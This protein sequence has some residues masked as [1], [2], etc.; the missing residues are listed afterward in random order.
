MNPH[1]LYNTLTSIKFMVQ[2]GDKEDASNTINALISLLQNT[3]G[4]ISETVSIEQEI[5]NLKNYVFINLKRYGNR[6]KVNY[7]VEPTCFS[8]QIPKLILQPFIENAF[9]HAFNHKLEGRINVLVWKEGEI[10]LCEITDDGDGMEVSEENSL[11][12]TKRNRKLFSGIGVKN[13]N[14]R[15]KLIYGDL[16]G[17][18]IKSELNIGTTVTIRIPITESKENTNN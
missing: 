17:V 9:F 7:L 16:Y 11:P 1:F 13:V 10:L 15:I 3:I 18:S 6:I 14:D 2:Q 12:E 5:I 8:Y 4:N